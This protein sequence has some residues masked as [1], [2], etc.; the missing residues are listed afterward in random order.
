MQRK[1]VD[2]F[3]AAKPPSVYPR[4]C[5]LP[6]W[7][8][9]PGDRCASYVGAEITHHI[10]GALAECADSEVPMFVTEWL[11]TVPCVDALD[12][13][14]NEDISKATATC[15]GVDKLSVLLAQHEEA[16][17]FFDSGVCLIARVFQL[18]NTQGFAALTPEV[19]CKMRKFNDGLMRQGPPAR[20]SRAMFEF[21]VITVKIFVL[22]AKSTLPDMVTAAIPDDQ[23]PAWHAEASEFIKSATVCNL[24]PHFE[25]MWFWGDAAELYGQGNI[26]EALPIMLD[27]WQRKARSG[28]D[29]PYLPYV[30]SRVGIDMS[31]HENQVAHATFLEFPGWDW[32][33][34]RADRVLRTMEAASQY[35]GTF[36]DPS[37][38]LNDCFA[39]MDMWC[40]HSSAMLALR[41]DL[42]SASRAAE[43]HLEFVRYVV[44]RL[45][46]WPAEIMAMMPMVKHMLVSYLMAQVA[47]ELL[48]S[49]LG[50]TVGAQA[51]VE[52]IRKISWVDWGRSEEISDQ[53]AV[54][55]DQLCVPRG[56]D[57]AS[58]SVGAIYTAEWVEWKTRFD[59]LKLSPLHGVSATDIGATLPTPEQL[60]GYSVNVPHKVKMTLRQGFSN[61]N[62]EAAQLCEKSG[63]L[64][65]AL[66]HADASLVHHWGDPQTDQRATTRI[67][68][69]ALRGRVLAAKGEMVAAEK[70]FEL[71]M[72][73]SDKVGTWLLTATTLRDL[74]CSHTDVAKVQDAA[75][76]LEQ[77]R[78]RLQ[79][80]DEELGL[81]RLLP[82]DAA[83]AIGAAMAAKLA[84]AP[85]PA[86]A[87][88]VVASGRSLFLLVES[89]LFT[90]K[91]KVSVAVATLEE[92][93][94]RLQEALGLV[95]TIGF[96]LWEIDFEEW[97]E[98][99][100]LKD[101]ETDKARVRVERR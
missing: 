28:G 83:A 79:G 96:S 6:A 76:R 8:R 9:Q 88:A 15:L 70:A 32:D 44:E 84:P 87:P 74:M 85:A 24:S 3:V 55:L 82:S 53:F 43:I 72:A 59:I 93:T 17:N 51:V 60:D 57:P 54:A 77:A 21:W 20:L 26:A 46:T 94:E 58:A 50:N 66:A 73:L 31:N 4:V 11:C 10:N 18:F 56:A 100:S 101:F 27:C 2:A 63:W 64:D 68:A 1:V 89:E 47:S 91:K 13:E 80:S 34:I 19:G 14:L 61:L 7:Q 52:T 30:L 62:L 75:R 71:A 49:V 98:V 69:Q 25:E 90:G 81:L 22:G 16:D 48:D 41:G 86:P 65:R 78:A 40:P 42:S 92:L 37:L 35:E 97:V 5:G 45:T 99:T 38:M 95:G 33:I 67:W 23:W 12:M 39:T 29:G 36:T